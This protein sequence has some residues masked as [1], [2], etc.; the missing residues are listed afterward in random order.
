MGAMETLRPLYNTGASL[1]KLCG[2]TRLN[3]TSIVCSQLAG[4]HIDS[5]GFD[6][7]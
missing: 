2:Y 6:I 1:A 7:K 5:H 4:P 3:S